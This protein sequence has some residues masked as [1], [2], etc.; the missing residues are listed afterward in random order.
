MKHF[1]I[2]YTANCLPQIVLNQRVNVETVAHIHYNFPPKDFVIRE[3]KE[4]TT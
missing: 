2:I 1:E 4:L 3:I